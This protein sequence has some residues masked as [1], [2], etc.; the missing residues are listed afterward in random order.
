MFKVVPLVLVTAA[1][2]ACSSSERLVGTTET[3]Q[4]SEVATPAVRVTRAPGWVTEYC[5]K[6][7]RMIGPP[8]LCPGWA[9]D[10]ISEPANLRVWRPSRGGYVFEA[11]ANTHWVF[12]ADRADVEANY[13]PMRELGSV[14]VGERTGRWLH[15]PEVAGIHAG[16]L[17]LTWR[18]GRFH[19]TIS[20]H[21]ENPEEAELRRELVAVAEGM[22]RFR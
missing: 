12:G 10:S 13:G 19:Y 22:R 17:V 11:H 20:A 7:G 14:R 5:V 21:T 9:P 8:V 4:G 1:V 16:H 15:A 2:A 3:S 6:A 18:D